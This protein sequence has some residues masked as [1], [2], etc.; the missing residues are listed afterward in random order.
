MKWNDIRDR[1]K[2]SSNTVMDSLQSSP[3]SSDPVMTT[4]DSTDVK[5]PLLKKILFPLIVVI[6][7]VAGAFAAYFV[8]KNKTITP[9]DSLQ[10]DKAEVSAVQNFFIE[11]PAAPITT[12]DMQKVQNILNPQPESPVVTPSSAQS[13]V[14][15]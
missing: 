6:V 7:I 10:L 4:V 1:L 12:T 15:N 2:K 5:K 8:F 14:K 9:S 11:N 3:V 13:A